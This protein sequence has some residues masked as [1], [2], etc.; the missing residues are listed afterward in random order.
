MERFTDGQ[1][2]FDTTQAT[3]AQTQCLL[4]PLL[5]PSLSVLLGLPVRFSNMPIVYG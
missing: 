5:P 2:K 3:S 1:P 4:L